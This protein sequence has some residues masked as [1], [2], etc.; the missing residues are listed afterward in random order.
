MPD[1]MTVAAPVSEVF[2]DVLDRA[3]C[4]VPVK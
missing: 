4:S 2:A 1:R 3:S